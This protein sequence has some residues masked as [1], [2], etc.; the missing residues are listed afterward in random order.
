MIAAAIIGL[1]LIFGFGGGV[2]GELMTKYAEDPIKTTIVEE[3]RREQAL[4]ELK[5]LEKAIKGLNKGVSKDIKAF[6]KLVEDYDSKPEDF[7][8]M[9][10]A[11][12]ER[13]EQEVS[14]IWEGRRALLTH[15]RADEW[16]TIISS[17][18]AGMEESKK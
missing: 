14:A 12:F 8:T 3:D 6:Q 9:L 18:K 16:Q 17:A 10:A 11:V 2:F 15:I 13:R 5:S 1:F 7:D 4:D